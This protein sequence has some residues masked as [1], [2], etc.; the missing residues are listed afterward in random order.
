[1]TLTVQ[2]YNFNTPYNLLFDQYVPNC[3]RSTFKWPFTLG[4][5]IDTETPKHIA[6][7]Q[8][9]MVLAFTTLAMAFSPFTISIG[10][11]I[12]AGFYIG[13]KI[14]RVFLATDP[15]LE[16]FH[17]ICGG[18]E[19]YNKLPYIQLHY[20]EFARSE[21]ES[22][23]EVNQGIHPP[24]PM[25]RASFHDREALLVKGED[26]Q[27]RVFVEKLSNSD[28]ENKLKDKVDKGVIYSGSMTA[29]Q[30]NALYLQMRQSC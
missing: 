13:N 24:K 11:A 12:L 19:K 26:N 29:H 28:F 27:F 4:R 25:Y 9:V 3:D 8:I 30:A 17:K 16:A 23:E 18:V 14:K 7:I 10:I 6:K 1:M 2:S 15:L 20:L 21:V 22:Y 5:T